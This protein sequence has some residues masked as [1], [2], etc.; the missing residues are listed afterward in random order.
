M[1]A[2][3]TLQLRVVRLSLNAGLNARPVRSTD[4]LPSD[5]LAAMRREFED[6]GLTLNGSLDAQREL[7][8]LRRSYEPY[9]LGLSNRLMVP[10]P[11][12]RHAA[13]P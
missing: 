9:V 11:P 13:R 7:V 12:W 8:E 10:V 2:H 3:L 6:A 1:G 5:E 4:R